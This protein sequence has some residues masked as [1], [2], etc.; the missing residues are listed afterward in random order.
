MVCWLLRVMDVL[1]NVTS[2]VGSFHGSCFD[3]GTLLTVMV[4][5]PPPHTTPPVTLPSSGLAG[6]GVPHALFADPK[7]GT[8]LC[9]LPLLCGTQSCAGPQGSLAPVVGIMAS[10]SACHGKDCSKQSREMSSFGLS[11][12]FHLYFVVIFTSFFVCIQ[13]FVGCYV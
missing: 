5:C 1:F 6:Y 10:S 2:W 9:C 13:K 12:L 3:A 7:Q 8:G 11:E 4:T